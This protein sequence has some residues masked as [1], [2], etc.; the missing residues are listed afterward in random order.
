MSLKITKEFR[1]A[2][3]KLILSSEFKDYI[4]YK[5]TDEV[6]KNG[7]YLNCSLNGRIPKKLENE[8]NEFK[9]QIYDLAQ[10][11]LGENSFEAVNSLMD[12]TFGAGVGDKYQPIECFD[13]TGKKTSIIHSNQ[14]VLMIDFWATWCKYCQEPMQE[15]INFIQE[16]S[17]SGLNQKISI[18]GLSCDEDQNKWKDHIK[19]KAWGIIPH[20]VKANVRK[21]LNIS[22][23]PY[24][25]I[26]GKDGLIK[27]EG[28]PRQINLKETLLNLNEGKGA[29]LVEEKWDDDSKNFDWNNSFDELKKEGMVYDCYL[30]MKN[31]GV[32]NAEFIVYTKSLLQQDGS[33]K[34]RTQVFIQGEIMEY[35]NEMI[36]KLI[37][38]YETQY[39]FANIQ[40]KTKLISISMTDEDF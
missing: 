25:I 12:F 26:V 1:E 40:K 14:Q 8:F 37:P 23:I 20:Y 27:Y 13:E 11:H 7:C 10:S 30:K 2:L 24:I 16:I 33:F 31:S 22:S 36:D 9:E 19:S 5:E 35:E 3:V 6:T 28:H 34:K 4:S 18:V 39:K 21:V 15:N 17:Q 38:V 32:K 29:S